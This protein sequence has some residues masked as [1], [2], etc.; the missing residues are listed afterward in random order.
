MEY[1]EIPINQTVYSNI[2]NIS[3]GTVTPDRV[4]TY[5]DASGSTVRRQGYNEYIDTGSGLPVDGLFNW[6]GILII[7]TDGNVYKKSISTPLTLL[8]SDLFVKGRRVTWADCNGVLYAANGGKI[9][10][11]LLDT[12]S[13]LTDP[14]I[15]L[16]VTHIVMFDRYLL[17]NSVGTGQVYHSKVGEPENFTDGGFFS[18]EQS[19]DNVVAIHARW[20]TLWVFG[21]DTVEQFYNDGVTPFVPLNGATLGIGCNAPYSVQWIRGSF[22]W[23]NNDHQIV[24]SSGNS[25]E[26]ISDPVENFLTKRFPEINIIGDFIQ[27]K[28][29]QFYILTNPDYESD[30]LT[31]IYDIISKEWQGRWSFWDTKDKRFRGQSYV[32]LES[33]YVFGDYNNGIIYIFGD[34][35]EDYGQIMRSAWLTG[36]L[37]HGSLKWKRSSQLRFRVL[38]GEG[39]PDVSY[40]LMVRWKNDGNRE[41]S[42][43]KYIDLGKLGDYNYYYTINRLGKY[44]MRQ[45]EFSITDNVPCIIQSAEELVG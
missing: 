36:W 1:L 10:K 20:N 43:V 16:N 13:A 15:P 11:I 23:L 7:V 45:Y 4:N 18:A 29:R 3:S 34:D 30:G 22:Y 41:W 2:D 5:R 19:P 17:A 21:E 35:Y 31:L 32:K 37:N 38:R 26:V 14:V 42:N 28:G 39:E 44:R 6:N 9:I 27:M 40:Q 8:G 12:A 24:K 25:Y 33:D